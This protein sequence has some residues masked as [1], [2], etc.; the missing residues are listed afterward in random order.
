MNRCLLACALAAT[1]TTPLF[2]GGCDDCC[3]QEETDIIGRVVL[4]GVPVASA[5]VR[6]IFNFTILDTEVTILDGAF[7]FDNWPEHWSPFI[8]EAFYIDPVTLNEYQGSTPFI[9]TNESGPTNVG[10][11]VLVQTFPA[12]AGG[13]TVAPADLDGDSVD[14]LAATYP[15]AIVLCLSSGESRILAHARVTDPPFGPILAA[16]LD[17]DGLKDLHVTRIGTPVKDVWKGDGTGGFVLV[18]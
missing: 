4:A 9:L 1:L 16:D 12:T 2:L 3:D 7:F 17:G 18:E 15:G 10:D 14:D 11:I 5:Q 6:A 8:V 13:S